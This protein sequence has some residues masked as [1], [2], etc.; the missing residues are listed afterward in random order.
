M[1]VRKK[2]GELLTE[3]GLID[4][5]QLKAALS[6]QRNWGG[7]LGEIIVK[8]GF[9]DEEKLLNFLS[10]YFKLPKVDLTKFRIPQEVLK[11]ITPDKARKFMAI[12]LG[13]KVDKGKKI[14]YVAI[15]DPTN[16]SVIDEI[17]F[18]TGM[19]VQPV[20][21]TD[22]AVDA[23]IKYYYEGHS[24]PPWEAFKEYGPVKKEGE[25]EFSIK[26]NSFLEKSAE[27][28]EKKISDTPSTEGK[29]FKSIW[30][31]DTDALLKGLILV[32]IKKGLITI[33]ELEEEL[34]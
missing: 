13:I 17:A 6:H 10:K 12:P 9:L 31:Y 18:I 1:K 14:L 26:D 8:L 4:D 27:E 30:D 33:T 28:V 23:A 3:A 25:P 34:E 22:I 24:V 21:A 16:I 2:M 29:T 32:L 5:N 7:R 20:I 11:F 19:T 15:T